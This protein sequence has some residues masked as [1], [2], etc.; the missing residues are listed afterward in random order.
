MPRKN[1][2]PSTSQTE[3][4]TTPAVVA[5]PKGKRVYTFLHLGYTKE[6]LRIPLGS[7]EMISDSRKSTYQDSR[8]LDELTQ[9]IQAE[10]DKGVSFSKVMT[11]TRRKASD[12][13]PDL[14]KIVLEVPAEAGVSEATTE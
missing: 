8:A 4:T 14:G 6:G 3:V 10:T 9:A 13:N 11:F 7:G 5:I 2:K 12:S 1:Q